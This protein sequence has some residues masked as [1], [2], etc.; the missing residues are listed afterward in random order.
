MLLPKAVDNTSDS[1]E[2][3]LKK[4]K[5]LL[6]KDEM[7]IEIKFQ[8]HSLNWEIMLYLEKCKRFL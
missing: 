8:V 7:S 3:Y 2:A 1:S 6:R 4:D 5:I